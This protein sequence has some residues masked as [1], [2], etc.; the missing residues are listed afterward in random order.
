MPK[1]TALS[2]NSVAVAV[3]AERIETLVRKGGFD[4]LVSSDDTRLSMG[5]GVS[6]AILSAAGAAL[7]DEAQKVVPLRLGD[8]AVTSAGD[9]PARY[10]LHAATVN[11]DLAVRP[12]ERT[13][14]LAAEN[15]FRRC[16]L[17]GV[18]RLAMPALGIGAA[19]FSA[20][21]SARLIVGALAEHA[22]NTTVLEQVVFSLP[23]AHARIS[24]SEYLQ[25]VLADV[26]SGREDDT[27]SL[28]GDSLTYGLS[29]V[30]QPADVTQQLGELPQVA[31]HPL[32]TASPTRM[33]GLKQWGRGWRRRLAGS[34]SGAN[35]MTAP[36]RS[37]AHPQ[38]HHAKGHSVVAPNRPLVSNRYVLLEELGRGGMGVVYLSWDIVL[39]QVVA[40]KTLRP[41][42]QVARE[43]AEAL[44][45]EAALQIG[46]VHEGIVRLLNFEPWDETV[47]P[48]IIMEYLSWTSG[49]RW[50][51]EAGLSRLPVRSVLTVGVRLCEALAYAH[52]SNVL[53]GDIKPSNVFIDPTGDRAKLAD[54][55]IARVIGIRERSAL[56]T[57]LVGTVAYMAPEQKEFGARV[58]PW[59]DIYLLARTLA[60]LIGARTT[61]RGAVEFPGDVWMEP[62]VSVLRR[63]L[64]PEPRNRPTDAQEFGRL[65]S[66]ALATFA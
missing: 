3:V 64:A 9:L 28:S 65:L 10:I 50:I 48:Y 49:D 51:A 47:G 59:T 25:R 56:V 29:S 42:E 16:E 6:G 66:G 38:P 26:Q 22:T 45:R 14:C 11:W 63:G 19:Q 27:Q 61:T 40:I 8:V 1:G 39:R 57:T 54:F 15:V 37:S 34:Q 31:R 60:D 23:D 62:A 52:T 18:R 7:R 58:G 41:G 44:R 30:E 53:H 5:G 20:D 12:S 4:A 35:T 21:D 33:K 46:L 13:I 17:L 2:I 36:G 24:F 55:G 43:R 32:P